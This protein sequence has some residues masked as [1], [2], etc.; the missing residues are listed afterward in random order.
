[1]G[2]PDATVLGVGASSSSNE[3]F[4]P[5]GEQWA[6]E[7]DEQRAVIVEV[8]GGLRVYE[9]GGYAVVDAY[10]PGEMSPGG[11]GA[12][13]APWP[14]RIRDGRYTFG[15]KEQ[16][17]ALTEPAWSNASHG[18]LRW[19]PWQVVD[20]QPDA[21]TIAATVHPQPG[22]PYAVQVETRWNLQPDGLHVDQRAT[23]VGTETAPFGLGMHPYLNLEGTPEPE[24]L[25]T[26][27][28][29][30][31]LLTDDRCLPTE[32]VNVED[33]EY[34]FRRPRTAAGVQ[35]DTPFTGLA[36]DERGHAVSTIAAADG[37]RVELWMDAAF[38]WLQVFTADGLP[39]PRTRRSWAIEPMTCPPDAF[40]SGND[41]VVLE[42]GATWRGSWGLRRVAA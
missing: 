16:R 35:L 28:A 33:T 5:S 14:N 30:R 31:R 6:I 38:R 19:Q 40:N 4:C 11:A 34:D 42:S 26:L 10:E 37:T 32:L 18:L 39:A 23:N 12:T 1:L 21:I 2:V 22:Y 17:L 36:R 27:P 15:G 8:G 24:W 7:S 13:L 29:S 41:L 20:H 25:L 9:A 3:L